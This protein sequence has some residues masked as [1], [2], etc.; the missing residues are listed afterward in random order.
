MP[1]PF[2]KY[3]PLLLNNYLTKL[4]KT[5]EKDE[6]IIFFITTAKYY[7]DNHERLDLYAVDSFLADLETTLPYKMREK[8]F[9][10]TMWTVVFHSM[11]IYLEEKEEAE[12]KDEED[13]YVDEEFEE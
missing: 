8:E 7:I 13:T 6:D 1:L 12:H 11:L 3:I 4:E 9:C 2:Y 10:N 5:Y